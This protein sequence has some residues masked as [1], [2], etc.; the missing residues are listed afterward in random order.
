MEA[1][2]CVDGSASP[3]DSGGLVQYFDWP[4]KCS[5]TPRQFLERH[6]LPIPGHR[7]FLHLRLAQFPELEGYFDSGAATVEDPI[8]L[9]GGD[10][11]RRRMHEVRIPAKID[12]QSPHLQAV[13]APANLIAALPRL[14]S[15]IAWCLDNNVDYRTFD[16]PGGDDF[17]ALR[18]ACID[19]LRDMYT[20]E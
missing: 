20:Q 19:Y 5:E 6:E 12:I 2:Y 9:Q 7:R 1:A 18:S 13:F 3:F 8:G 11:I 4:T 17:S 15:L 16:P 14:R 10:P